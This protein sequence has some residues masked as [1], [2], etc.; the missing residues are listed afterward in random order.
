MAAAASTLTLSSATFAK[1]SPHPY[2]L[3]NLQ[4]SDSSIPSARTNGRQ[5][6]Q[7]RPP[8]INS[9]SLSHAHGSAVVRTGDTTV[10]CGVRAETLLTNQIPNYRV[11]AKDGLASSNTNE[12]R[13]YDL[14]VPNIELATGCAPNFLPGVPPTAIAQTLSTRVYSL[15]HSSK[16][17]DAADLRITYQNKDL[18][19]RLEGKQ[20]EEERGQDVAHGNDGAGDNSTQGEVKAYWVLYID[21]LFISLDGNP[22]DAAWA[23]IVAALRDTKLPKAF[24][25]PDREMVLCNREASPLTVRGLPVASTAAVF[26]AKERQQQKK[27]SG[28]F[29][30]LV[31]PDRLEESLC[32]ESVTVVVDRSQGETEVLGLS[33][34]GGTIVGPEVLRRFTAIAEER[35]EEFEKALS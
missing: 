4:P 15:L 34:S 27:G 35:W 20:E 5:P 19:P 16:L 11:Q 17:L 1:L 8:F 28:Q 33:K 6:R 10:I 25:D 32:H 30:I 2:L 22:F 3:A 13:D 31:D 26:T 29:W 14:L 21:V 24:W 7:A 23:S 9:S 18:P 12:L